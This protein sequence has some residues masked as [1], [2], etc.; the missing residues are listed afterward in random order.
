VI[1]LV[2]DPVVEIVLSHRLSRC[3]RREQRQ[4]Q[5]R[6]TIG[7]RTKKGYDPFRLDSIIKKGS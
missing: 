3:R 4:C 5:R 6:G 2:E 7:C 1:D